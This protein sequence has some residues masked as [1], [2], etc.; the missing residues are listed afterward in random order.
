MLYELVVG[1]A[2]VEVVVVYCVFCVVV[3]EK[4]KL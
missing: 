1:E 3:M 2:E 4:K